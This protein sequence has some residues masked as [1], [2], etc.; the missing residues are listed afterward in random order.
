LPENSKS[1]SRYALKEQ[2]G[3]LD[4]VNLR[5]LDE[6][7]ADPRMSMSEL[8]RRVGMSAPAV[9][10]R[11]QRLEQS[12]VIAGYR[13]EL[14]PAA[15]G[16]PVTVFV[17]VRT[18]ATGMRSFPEFVATVPQVVECYRITGE[19]CFIVKMQVAGVDRLTEIIDRFFFYGD[20][21]TS[22]VMDTT[23]PPRQLPLDAGQ[24]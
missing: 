11:V 17:R 15:L 24:D 13:M 3:V 23:V 20:T 1:S 19:D 12:G 21:T 14:D 5:L 22:I 6:L 16:L 4:Q 9:T 7:G 18:N 8:A 10:E 2:P